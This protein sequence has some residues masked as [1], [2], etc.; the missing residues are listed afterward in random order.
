MF[1][2]QTAFK[3]NKHY[4]DA[5]KVSEAEHRN[6]QKRRKPKHPHRYHEDKVD[7]TF[8]SAKK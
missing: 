7:H 6:A 8:L 1:V 4:Y 5:L 2:T 3:R